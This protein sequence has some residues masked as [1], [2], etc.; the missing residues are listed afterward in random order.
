[1]ATNKLKIFPDSYWSVYDGENKT[2]SGPTAEDRVAKEQEKTEG[3]H[4]YDTSSQSRVQKVA[5]VGL[6]VQ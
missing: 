1:M 3:V 2:E 5:K 6:G 4:S